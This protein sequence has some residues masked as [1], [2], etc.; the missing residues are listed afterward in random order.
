MSKPATKRLTKEYKEL[1]KNPVELVKAVRP[2]DDNL[3]ECHF[4]VSLF[5]IHCGFQ[6]DRWEL[7]PFISNFFKKLLAKNLCAKKQTVFSYNFSFFFFK[8]VLVY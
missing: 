4:C 7:I 2:L 8:V 6:V 3:H 5:S 1:E